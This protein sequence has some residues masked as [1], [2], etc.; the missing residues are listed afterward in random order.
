[1]TGGHCEPI[2]GKDP[3][4]GPIRLMCDSTFPRRMLQND[5]ES[6][7]VQ[8][9][10]MNPHNV[11]TESVIRNGSVRTGSERDSVRVTRSRLIGAVDLSISEDCDP[12]GDPYNNTGQHVIIKQ[13]TDLQD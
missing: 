11:K 1:M 5:N 3:I 2:N 9:K 7:P 13:K 6:A 10:T 4:D 12:G 8:G